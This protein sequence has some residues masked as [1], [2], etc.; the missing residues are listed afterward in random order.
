MYNTIKDIIQ[1][2]NRFCKTVVLLTR[3]GTKWH[4][5]NFFVWT[6]N[7]LGK[8]DKY[9]HVSLQLLWCNHYYLSN[10]LLIFTPP[11]A[12]PQILLRVTCFLVW[13]ITCTKHVL[14][15]ILNDIQPNFIRIITGNVILH[16]KI[17]TLRKTRS[18]YIHRA[19]VS[20]FAL[21]DLSSHFFTNNICLL[22]IF[23]VRHI[24]PWDVTKSTQL[25]ILSST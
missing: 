14:T 1:F 11:T 24:N 8:I 20:C 25:I 21:L 23:W 22:G 7:F 18:M 9:S 3:S 17:V 5:R 13:Y 12:L 15:S 16:T 10:V 19:S 4:Q 6:Q 2:G